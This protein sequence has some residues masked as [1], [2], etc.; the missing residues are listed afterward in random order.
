MAPK[1]GR[2]KKGRREKGEEVWT[3]ERVVIPLCKFKRIRIVRG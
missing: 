1:M 3:E 2:A